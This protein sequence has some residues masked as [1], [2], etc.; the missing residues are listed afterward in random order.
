MELWFDDGEWEN[1]SHR[2]M[3]P[4]AVVRVKTGVSLSCPAPTSPGMSSTRRRVPLRGTA[5][6]SLRSVRR[7][8]RWKGSE[9]RRMG[10]VRWTGVGRSSVELDTCRRDRTLADR[11]RREGVR[12]Q[13]DLRK[14]R[15][16][17]PLHGSNGLRG[18][19]RLGGRVVV[20]EDGSEGLHRGTVCEAAQGRRRGIDNA[21][22][23][24]E[25][26][27]PCGR[28]Y[29]IPCKKH[30]VL[31]CSNRYDSAIGIMD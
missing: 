24:C 3:R 5:L 1:V 4:A 31:A 13:T 29:E 20:A 8:Y 6:F 26:G 9:A 23:A 15:G 17:L 21:V 19:V 22:A 28:P 10:W 12:E 16:E 18:L 2:W 14:G 7:L 30:R 11:R 27:P 25:S